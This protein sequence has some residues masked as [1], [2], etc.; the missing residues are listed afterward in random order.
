MEIIKKHIV[1]CFGSSLRFI[2][3]YEPFLEDVDEIAKGVGV[4]GGLKCR[5]IYAYKWAR[6]PVPTT[7]NHPTDV[8]HPVRNSS[9]TSLT[10]I[11]RKK[12]SD[13]K[14]DQR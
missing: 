10:R 14:N 5:R 4:W 1:F 12:K 11:K 6:L 7:L 9:Y 8:F 13:R 2:I 3:N